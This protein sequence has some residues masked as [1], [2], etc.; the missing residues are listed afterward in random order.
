MKKLSA[1]YLINKSSNKSDAFVSCLK[2]ALPGSSILLYEDA[3]LNAINASPIK[4]ELTQA[5]TE[6]SIYVLLPDLQAR[7][8]TDL[9]ITGIKT[10][11]YDDFV[12]L[13]TA[14]H[15]VVSWN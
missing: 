1:L 13:V 15:P 8:M 14:H 11:Q 10:I 7:G 12:D 2:R 4:Q 5:L 3:V 9:L 6:F